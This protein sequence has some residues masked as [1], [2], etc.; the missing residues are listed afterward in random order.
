[1]T[2]VSSSGLFV[3]AWMAVA[4]VGTGVAMA[5]ATSA[6]LVELSEEKSG[7][8]SAVLQAVNKTGGPLGIAILG[9]VLSAGYLARLT[10]SGVPAAA[11]AAARQSVF[12]GVAAAQTIHSASLLASVRNAFVHGMD[13]ALLVS[14]GIGM[15]GVVLT[16][17]FL[18][19]S[20]TSRKAAQSRMVAQGQ[21]V[22][23]RPATTGQAA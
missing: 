16:L 13:M 8:G 3:A 19:R 10:L 9:S 1:M 17:L 2:S 12:S 5:T 20:N 4:G 21:S 15:T 6:A 7:V 22:G 11:S 23:T 14:G 18:P